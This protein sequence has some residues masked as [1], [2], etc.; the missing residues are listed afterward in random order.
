M[1]STQHSSQPSIVAA[2][3]SAATRSMSNGLS[4]GLVLV[5]A[6]L[7]LPLGG[8]VAWDVATLPVKATS[9][10]IDWT[11][12][13]QDEAD[14]NGGRRMRKAAQRD[15]QMGDACGRR[16]GDCRGADGVPIYFERVDQ[17]EAD[18]R[19]Q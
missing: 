13:S 14:R 7:P 6:A 15:R 11:T 4:P 12:T 16:S 1:K 5:T 10:A 19:G 17:P 18:P 8:C 9:K 3:V 2:I